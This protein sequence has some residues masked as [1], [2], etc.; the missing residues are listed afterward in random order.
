MNNLA[1]LTA[2]L[3]AAGMVMG[4]VYEIQAVDNKNENDARGVTGA[5][6][7]MTDAVNAALLRVPG[8]PA[9]AVF[10]NRSGQPLWAVE[11]VSGK[12]V[13]DVEVNAANGAILQQSA[14]RTDHAG[15]DEADDDQAAGRR[16]NP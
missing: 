14:D 3:L 2:S 12:G 7:S 6:V 16:E 10:E 15:D 1:K 11:I 8:K 5:A 13:F 4:V 9:R